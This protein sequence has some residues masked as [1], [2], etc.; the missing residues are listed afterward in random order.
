MW[1]PAMIVSIMKTLVAAALLLAVAAGGATGHVFVRVPPG[2]EVFVDGVSVG[3]STAEEEGRIIRK[4]PI[5][6]HRVI[7]RTPDSRQASFIVT[8]QQDQTAEVRVSPLGFRKLSTPSTSDD[9]GAVRVTAIPADSSVVL[10]GVTRENHDAT[11]LNFEPVPAGKHALVVTY[12]TRTL[13]ADV[14][15][16]KGM[17]VTVQMNPKTATVR[18]IETKA[19]PRR[20]LIA[21]ANDALSR[22]GIPSHWRSAIRTALPSTVSILDAAAGG[23]AV[24]VTLKVPS[25]RMAESLLASLER[26]TSFSRVAFGSQPRRDQAGWVVDFV[27][28]FAR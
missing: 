1:G 17:S 20:M 27:F 22:L 10:N 23:N 24:R 14:D 21:E 15:V 7:V 28:E 25:D 18:V 6:T 3:L 26:S 19:R 5:G 9:A 16:P 2:M 12:G 13:R 11:E 4:L 8:V